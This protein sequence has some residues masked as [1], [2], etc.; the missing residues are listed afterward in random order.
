MAHILDANSGHKSYAPLSHAQTVELAQHLDGKHNNLEAK[1]DE[2]I[3]ALQRTDSNV[4][5]L[6]EG[7]HN[8]GVVVTTVKSELAD[9]NTV[10]QGTRQDL[11]QCA[12]NVNTISVGLD[13]MK[14]N[15][16]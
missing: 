7:L 3:K 10:L 12:A 9:T 1:V 13:M 14:E 6:R 8:L 5:E 2:L 11:E 4:S 15:V 16:D